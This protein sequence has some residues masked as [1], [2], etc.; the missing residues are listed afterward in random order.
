MPPGGGTRQGWEC[1][2]LRCRKASWILAGMMFVLIPTV[3]LPVTP[4]SMPV[5]AIDALD[6]PRALALSQRLSSPHAPSLH[7]RPD[8]EPSAEGERAALGRCPCTAMLCVCIAL[9]MH[10]DAVCIAH[11]CCIR[12]QTT[13]SLPRERFEPRSAHQPPA[14]P[15]LDQGIGGPSV[16]S[17]ASVVQRSGAATELEVERSGRWRQI[18]V[19]RA[20][21]KHK[22]P[23]KVCADTPTNT[24]RGMP[25]VQEGG[26][27]AS[28]ARIS[29]V[30]LP[31]GGLLP[32][33]VEGTRGCAYDKDGA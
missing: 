25:R 23:R 8:L 12:S 6:G 10:C 27:W 29:L 18:E 5:R 33:Q 14:R 22:T 19:G 17:G 9:S 7:P 20:H 21:Q 26:M 31:A 32:R 1:M 11:R 13:A 2:Q 16:G 28:I 30:L 4:A 15:Q 3:S 24:A